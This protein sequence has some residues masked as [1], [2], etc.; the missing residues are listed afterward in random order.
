MAKDLICNIII[1]LY[2]DI[3]DHRK[4]N[5]IIKYIIS[6]NTIG[7][8]ILTLMHGIR[9]NRRPPHTTYYLS[10]YIHK[11]NAHNR[12]HV[13]HI[14]L[15]HSCSYFSSIMFVTYLLKPVSE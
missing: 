2:N 10:R 4:G 1:R 8:Y 9:T 15:V 11:Y 5:K 3:F 14:L 6:I 7:W 13:R 12:P